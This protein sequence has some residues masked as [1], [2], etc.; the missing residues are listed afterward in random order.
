[1]REPCPSY[2]RWLDTALTG[3]TI[4]SGA[5]GIAVKPNHSVG[6]RVEGITVSG[7]TIRFGRSR[8]GETGVEFEVWSGST[9]NRISDV[10]VARNS[11]EG[12]GAG[13]R[14]YA[15]A[16]RSPGNT[17]EG[18]QIVDNRIRLVRC[19]SGI[20]VGAGGGSP[21]DVNPTLRPI[22]YPDGNLLRNVEI[23]RNTMIGTFFSGVTVETCCGNG[24]R[25]RI[26]RIRVERNMI[27]SSR[28]GNGVLVQAGGAEPNYGRL[29]TGN[30]VSGVS[31]IAN[32]IAVGGAGP[33]YWDRDLSGGIVLL[34]GAK[35]GRGNSV[36]DVRITRN[37]I[38][39]VP[40]GINVVGGLGGVKGNE[41]RCVRLAGNRIP[42]T[43]KAVSV[44]S[45]V[46]GASGNRA[47]LGGC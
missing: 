39:A 21:Q 4:E 20:S 44:R 24:S 40:G 43:R 3:N 35:F 46:G 15:G 10:L 47:S 26:E 32:T 28:I 41:V 25:N 14:V 6:D 19:C 8:A 17:V 9:R 2:N 36:R 38:T 29:P 37:R 30:R 12:S 22:R 18:I 16:G 27:R 5:T 45:N 11:I 13:M 31:I 7:N 23:S 33:A 42:G 34:G 1:V